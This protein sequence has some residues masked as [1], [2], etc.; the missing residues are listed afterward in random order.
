MDLTWSDKINDKIKISKVNQLDK[1]F[2][3]LHT[4]FIIN[5]SIF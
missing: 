4:T 3:Y 5:F 2:G 1:L